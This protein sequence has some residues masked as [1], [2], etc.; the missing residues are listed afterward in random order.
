MKKLMFIGL[1]FLFLVSCQSID[2]F[3]NDIPTSGIPIDQF[4]TFEADFSD[5]TAYLNTFYNGV[6]QS[7]IVVVDAG[8]ELVIEPIVS[9]SRD[10]YLEVYEQSNFSFIRMSTIILS[11]IQDFGV[12]NKVLDTYVP[13]D[14]YLITE[15]SPSVLNHYIVNLG[16]TSYQLVFENDYYYLS[17]YTEYMSKNYQ[18][19]FLEDGRL[20]F[21]SYSIDQESS[22]INGYYEFLEDSYYKELY[23]GEND[24]YS[25]RFFDIELQQALIYQN[26]DGES[27]TFYDEAH[28]LA[29][30]QNEDT[31]EC[32]YYNSYGPYFQYVETNDIAIISW[33]MLEVSGWDNVLLTSSGDV[34][35][36]YQGD[37][38]LLTS[39]FDYVDESLDQFRFSANVTLRKIY[40]IS[41]VNDSILGLNNQGLTLL[42]EPLTLNKLKSDAAMMKLNYRMLLTIDGTLIDDFRSNDLIRAQISKDLIE[43]LYKPDFNF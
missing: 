1:L 26:Q 7:D 30:F 23:F 18:I 32:T 29:Y 37:I 42:F 36:I 4:L 24:T 28:D 22:L 21:K 35:G 13:S 27:Y 8:D 20:Y 41:G 2:D 19:R 16:N 11:L 6:Y 39:P 25:F 3:N 10:E 17:T 5:K 15:I 34:E 33:Q 40:P 38:N 31:I 9:V 43:A 12:V 14:S